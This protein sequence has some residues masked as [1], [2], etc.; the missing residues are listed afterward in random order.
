VQQ[1]WVPWQVCNFYEPWR[2]HLPFEGG[3]FTSV[4]EA[5]SHMCTAGKII[6]PNKQLANYHNAKHQIFLKMYE[7]ALS[8]RSIMASFE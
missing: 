8:Y 3:V 5:M 7:D 4:V 6:A 2:H 1:S